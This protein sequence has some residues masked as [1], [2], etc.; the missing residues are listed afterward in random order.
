MR[1]STIAGIAVTAALAAAPAALAQTSTQMPTKSA[2][3]DVVQT[4]TGCLMTEPAYRSAHN[5]G[6]GALGGAGLGDEFVLVDAKVSPAKSAAETTEVSA[7]STPAAASASTQ[8][9]ADR[10][11]AYRLTG[12]TEER[13]KGLVGHEL[14][15]QGKFKHADDVTAAG[16]AVDSKLPAEV[17]M[18]SYREAPAPMPAPAAVTQPAPPATPPTSTVEPSR[19]TPPPPPPAPEPTTVAPKELPHTAGSGYALALV[20]VLALGSGVLITLFRRR[21]A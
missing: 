17:E 2:E 14:E 9:C 8:T 19:T 10:G 21:T 5:L 15:V 4:F 12:H 1:L 13:L 20:G 7:S 3:K 18:V 11:V 16:T 6:K